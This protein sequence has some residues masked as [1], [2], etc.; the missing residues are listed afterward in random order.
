MSANARTR[1][2]GVVSEAT[3]CPSLLSGGS[4]AD[5]DEDRVV[6]APRRSPSGLQTR[7]MLD[8]AARHTIRPEIETY[9]ATA[10]NDAVDHV[11]KGRARYR[12]V[13]EY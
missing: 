1:T 3:M 7:Q 8:F 4:S 9:P 13:V 5:F 2:S 6:R 11:R 10:I 12:V